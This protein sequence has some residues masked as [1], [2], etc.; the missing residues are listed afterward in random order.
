MRQYFQIKVLILHYLSQEFRFETKC[1]DRFEVI[2][3][4]TDV[5]HFFRATLEIS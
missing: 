5:K 3:R 4:Q 2:I 1:V